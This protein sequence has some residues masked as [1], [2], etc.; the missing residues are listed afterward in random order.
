M[1][2]QNRQPVV[3]VLGHVDSGK[4]SL[5]DKIRG[6]AVQAREV[7]GMTQH[8]GASFFP[9]ETLRDICGPLLGL[10]GGDVTVP[11]LL[12]IDTPGHEVFANLRSRGGS[13]ADISILVVD[14][15]R[16]FEKQTYESLDIL[17]RQKVPFVVALNKLDRLPSWRKSTTSSKPPLLSE[18]IKEKTGTAV[19]ELDER[20][21]DVVGTL[22]KLGINSEAFYRIK[23]YTREI[24]LVPVSAVTG[25]GIPELLTVMLGLTQQY[26]KNRLEMTG[27]PGRGI[28]LEVKE[29]TGLGQTSDV[30][31]ING[32][33]RIGE[34]VV[35][36]KR[37]GPISTRIKAL[38]MPKPLDE[39][40]DPRDRFTAVDEV[41]AA[42]GVKL[43]APELDGVLAGSPILSAGKSGE[44]Q[45]L[46][47]QVESEVQ[48][49]FVTTEREGIVLRCDALG[50]LE[51]IVG[52]L[53]E[54][55]VPIRIGDIGP[56]NRR[57]VV[58]A[59]TVKKKDIYAGVILAFGVKVLPDAEQ[60]AVAAGVKIFTDPVIYNLVTSYFD[61]VE[62]ERETALRSEMS[63]LTPIGKFEILKG[64]TFRRNNP[65]VFGVEVLAG[66]VRQKAQVINSEGKTI[67][68]IHQIQDKGKTIT[69]ATAGDQVAVSMVRPTLGRHIQE[70]EQ[71]YILP[72]AEEAKL[73]KAKYATRLNAGE[74]EVLDLV[75]E[76]RRKVVPMYAF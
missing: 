45:G 51:A 20:I 46:M 67:D 44:I 76:L 71:L 59:A 43:V 24:A 16:G 73:L 68:V 21:Y 72:P 75:I 2:I 41:F 8:I 27:G 35:L 29:E 47:Q 56:V 55:D 58:E 5:L 17:R 54:K 10:V 63:H 39:M 74:I 50:S 6:T 64:T 4:T 53:Q 69:E 26:L 14:V 25:Q 37:E 3:A 33:L 48:S 23:D 62:T 31:L 38:F 49:I 52:M 30:I 34:V 11:G 7:G 13:A 57:D 42:A 36:S 1:E 32:S 9:I 40:R 65:A 60:A 61:W 22:S 66:R 19:D 28:V 12:V 70:G 15:T 18:S